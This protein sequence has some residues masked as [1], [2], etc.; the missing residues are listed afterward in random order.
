MNCTVKQ[1]NRKNLPCGVLRSQISK[2]C[3][4]IFTLIQSQFHIVC[5]KSGGAVFDE[6]LL[7]SVLCLCVSVPGGCGSPRPQ[8]VWFPV[9]PLPAVFPQKPSPKEE[10]E[11]KRSQD[12]HQ[13]QWQ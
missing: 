6:P 4:Y 2:L 9:A 12:L 5:N 7:L 13:N 11:R 8:Y 10:R 3:R 1:R